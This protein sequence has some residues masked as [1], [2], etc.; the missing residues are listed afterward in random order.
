[1][2]LEHVEVRH[3]YEVISGSLFQSFHY[4]VVH[5]CDIVEKVSSGLIEEGESG[6]ELMHPFNGLQD[7]YE[8]IDYV[9]ELEYPDESDLAPPAKDVVIRDFSLPTGIIELFIG[10]KFHEVIVEWDE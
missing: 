2:E 7:G 3:E 5:E 8:Q 10:G 1:M 4:E 6:V 9:V